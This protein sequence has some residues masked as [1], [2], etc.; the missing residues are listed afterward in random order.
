MLGLNQCLLDG[1]L[2]YLSWRER[3]RGRM[4]TLVGE[5]RL[6]GQQCNHLVRSCLSN[7]GIVHLHIS[8][9]STLL[10]YSVVLIVIMLSHLHL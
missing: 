9:V 2:K 4:I 3:L 6:G 7:L 10:K 5:L 1:E 8:L